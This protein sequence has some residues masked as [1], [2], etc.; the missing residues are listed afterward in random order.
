MCRKRPSALC[1]EGDTQLSPWIATSDFSTASFFGQKKQAPRSKEGRGKNLEVKRKPF[2]LYHWNQPFSP[3]NSGWIK[4]KF[5]KKYI[6]KINMFFKFLSQQRLFKLSLDI[7]FWKT[8]K[9]F[10]SLLFILRYCIFT[11]DKERGGEKQTQLD[12][13]YFTFELPLK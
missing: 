3:L 9:F 11:I 7:I 10:P 12:V 13:F 1:G 2:P 4:E 6:R 5:R 8:T